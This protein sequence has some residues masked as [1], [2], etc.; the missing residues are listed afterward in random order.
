MPLA[1]RMGG[2]APRGDL[3]VTYNL[4]SIPLLLQL[5]SLNIFIHVCM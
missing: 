2:H 3:L 1:E 5:E 4:C